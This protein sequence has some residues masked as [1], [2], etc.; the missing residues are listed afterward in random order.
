MLWIFSNSD[1]MWKSRSLNIAS[2]CPAGF[3]VLGIS[4]NSQDNFR[5]NYM[6]PSHISGQF[7]W[8]ALKHTVCWQEFLWA[9]LLNL[10]SFR[11]MVFSPVSVWVILFL[12]ILLELSWA[13]LYA[14]FLI[15]DIN[16]TL[17]L[18][19]YTLLLP[20]LFFSLKCNQG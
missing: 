3:Q 20:W 13:K 9:H 8:V 15:I 19:P 7:H 18:I 2:Y 6:F 16:F 14:I 10:F 4:C 17:N 5:T 12:L 1:Q 11:G